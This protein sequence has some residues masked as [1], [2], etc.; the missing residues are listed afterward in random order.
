MSTDALLEDKEAFYAQL[1]FLDTPSDE[2]NE[3]LKSDQKFRAR[4]RNFLNQA[5]AQARARSKLNSRKPHQ[6]AHIDT[7]ASYKNLEKVT[8]KRS[9][10]TP[11]PMSTRSAVIELTP[12]IL[13]QDRRANRRRIPVSASFVEDTPCSS[14]ISTLKRSVTNP[15]SSPSLSRPSSNQ[16]PSLPNMAKRKREDVIPQDQKWLRGLRLFYIP[17]DRI[18][19]RRNRM[20]HAERYGAVVTQVLADATHIIVDD[21]LSYD[22]IKD[23]EGMDKVVGKDTPVIVR[24]HWPIDSI[25]RKRLQPTNSV[26]YRV[27]GLPTAET[28]ATPLPQERAVSQASK[29]SLVL[30]AP[31]NNPNK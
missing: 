25:V 16:A 30:K 6:A 13:E 14:G 10:T 26:M 4:S 15:I 28:M 19:L 21:K 24:E 9:E 12:S 8:A 1:D 20:E 29:Q 11:T 23:E 22:D 3:T 5:Q 31:S 2:D 27:K 7:T 18:S 17:G